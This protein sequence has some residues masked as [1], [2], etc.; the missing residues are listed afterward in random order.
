[1][2]R[3]KERGFTLIELLIVIAVIGLLA[4]AILPRYVSFTHEAAAGAARGSLSSL[5][6]ALAIYVAQADGYHPTFANVET[7][8]VP[9]NID[10]IPS[11]QVEYD[12]ASE[13]YSAVKAERECN[14][15]SATY[16][17]DSDGWIYTYADGIGRFNINEQELSVMW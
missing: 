10:A 2:F 3:R 12:A 11:E 4:A 6:A 9:A 14:T 15:L 5:R 8:L 1:M 7:A 13:T 16:A 17:A